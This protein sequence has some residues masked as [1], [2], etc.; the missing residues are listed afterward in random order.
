MKVRTVASAIFLAATCASCSMGRV[1]ARMA[2]WQAEVDDHLPLGSALADAESFFRE[3]G[4]ALRCCASGPGFSDNYYALERDVGRFMWT[5]Y[6]VE[7][8]LEVSME[9]TVRNIRIHRIGVGL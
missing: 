9:Q 8:F 1:N 4:V 6:S 7:I 5:Q 3:R 2:Y